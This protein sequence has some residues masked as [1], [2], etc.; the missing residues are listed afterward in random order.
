MPRSGRR[1]ITSRRIDEW[2]LNMRVEFESQWLQDTYGAWCK[3][4]LL[5]RG[6]AERP[7]I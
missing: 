5:R 1:V 7:S 2:P 4:A 6:G 3:R